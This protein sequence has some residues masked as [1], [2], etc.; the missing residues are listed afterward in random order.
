MSNSVRV[1]ST[2]FVLARW[3][4]GAAVD[5]EKVNA[6][7]ID[8]LQSGDRAVSTTRA[9]KSL[10]TDR[11]SACARRTVRDGAFEVRGVRRQRLRRGTQQ[12]SVRSMNIDTR[13]FH[14]D[15]KSQTATSSGRVFAIFILLH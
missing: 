7:R 6:S 8:E 10:V 5:E 4:V 15:D 11:S 3:I 1:Q 9:D 2:R 14:L 12:P 13:E